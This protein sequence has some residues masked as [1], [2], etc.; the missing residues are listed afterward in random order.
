[1]RATLFLLLLLT[2]FG[3][4]LWSILSGALLFLGLLLWA[5]VSVISIGYFD[6]FVLYLIGAREIRSSDE[7]EFYEAASQEAYKL[8][9][10]MPQLYFYNGSLERAF[11]LQNKKSS[12]IILSKSLMEKC[13]P[14]DFK[15]ISFELLLQVKKGMATKRTKTMF[16]LGFFTWVTHSIVSI[17]SAIIPFKDLRKVSDWFL[18]FLLSPAWDLLFKVLVGENYFKK[19]QSSL[20]E[21]PEEKEN[22]ERLGLK[23]RK[24][25]EYYSIPSRKLLELKSVYRSRHYQNIL[26][27]EFLPHEWDF[28]FRKEEMKRAE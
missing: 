24:P 22:L 5:L 15:A 17:I 27:L 10:S 4:Y 20:S 25:F 3:L 8:T 2:V 16:V 13:T 12:S 19:L 21:F 26:G 23:L 1:M 28:L 18:I 7:K 14:E 11:I 9:V 6:T